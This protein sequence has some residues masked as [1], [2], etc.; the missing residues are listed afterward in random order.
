MICII[1]THNL[2]SLIISKKNVIPDNSVII[3]ICFQYANTWKTKTVFILSF[4]LLGDP[5][6]IDFDTYPLCVNIGIDQFLDPSPCMFVTPWQPI[7]ARA[8]I[9]SQHEITLTHMQRVVTN[10][11]ISMTGTLVD[12]DLEVS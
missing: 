9:W 4:Q 1:I 7:S 10:P 11:G 3:E 6:L 2:L 5:N 12:K 8:T